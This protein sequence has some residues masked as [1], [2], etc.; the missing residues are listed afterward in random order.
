MKQWAWATDRAGMVDGG[1]GRESERETSD[2]TGFP[3]EWQ[4][5]APIN[6]QRGLFQLVCELPRRLMMAVAVGSGVS[7]ICCYYRTGN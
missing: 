2:Q 4:M 6:C 1:G 5:E 7:H 3:T